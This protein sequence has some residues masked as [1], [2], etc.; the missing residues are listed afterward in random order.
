MTTKTCPKC[1][2]V[3]PATS[4]FFYAGQGRGRL[5]GYCKKCSAKYQLSWSRKRKLGI[6]EDKLDELSLKQNGKCAICGRKQPETGSHRYK[7]LAVDHCH[8]TGKIRGLLCNNCNRALGLFQDSPE[9]L[10][11]AA[12]YLTFNEQLRPKLKVV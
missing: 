3:F 8:E 6:S 7:S 12:E 11:R 9:L 1:S 10:C 5:A 4:E 2:T